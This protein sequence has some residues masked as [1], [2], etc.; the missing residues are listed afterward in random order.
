M[1]M[2]APGT[3]IA[4]LQLRNLSAPNPMMAPN[5][6]GITHCVTP[7]PRFPQPAVTALAVPTTDRENMIEVWYCV[8][9]NEAPTSP[10]ASRKNKKEW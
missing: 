6:R 1:N 3:I 9:T 4:N 2:R 5:N 10:M 7:P 8:R